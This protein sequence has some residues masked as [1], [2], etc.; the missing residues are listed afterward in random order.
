VVVGD[1][2]NGFIRGDLMDANAIVELV[3]NIIGGAPDTLDTLK[4][5][6]DRIAALE[7]DTR[8]WLTQDDTLASKVDG[9]FK[10]LQIL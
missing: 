1:T 8:D 10:S 9:L 7:H 3:N 2:A 5:A 6:A 4:E